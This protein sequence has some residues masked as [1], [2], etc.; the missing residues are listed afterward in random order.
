MLELGRS[1]NQGKGVTKNYAEADDVEALNEVGW[2]Y[3][4]GWGLTRAAVDYSEPMR[5]Y[6]KAAAAGDKDAQKWLAE[7]KQ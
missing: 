6:R 2:L 7:L 1:Y 5:W 4:I 3:L